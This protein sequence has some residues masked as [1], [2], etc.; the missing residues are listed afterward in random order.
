MPDISK[1]AWISLTNI[2]LTMH[3]EAWEIHG[4]ES[5][6][7]ILG[8]GWRSYEQQAYKVTGVDLL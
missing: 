5:P 3:S 8:I 2:D 1:V 6:Y 7:W 4:K